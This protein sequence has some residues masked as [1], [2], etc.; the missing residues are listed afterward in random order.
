MKNREDDHA[1]WRCFNAYPCCELI[2]IDSVIFALLVRNWVGEALPWWQTNLSSKSA[3]L[4]LHNEMNKTLLVAT[5]MWLLLLGSSSAIWADFTF[6]FEDKQGI[7]GVTSLTYVK[8]ELTI[9]ITRTSGATF[10]I[11]SPGVNPFLSGS[12]SPFNGD[13]GVYID[14][15]FQIELS[16]PVAAFFI[17]AGD[18]GGDLDSLVLEGFVGPG[19]TGETAGWQ[20]SLPGGGSNFGYATM[21]LTRDPDLPG[22]RSFRFRGGTPVA[23]NSVYYDNIRF[24]LSSV[25]EP[26]AAILFALACASI[27]AMRSF[28]STVSR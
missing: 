1:V 6:D 3:P 16:R 13:N 24:R 11:D 17:D 23:P 10:D 8:P 15:H 9:T 19:L 5:A 14:D 20:G 18:S 25:P 27:G 2:A 26:S 28:R 22:F 12:L 21:Q 4:H 7:A